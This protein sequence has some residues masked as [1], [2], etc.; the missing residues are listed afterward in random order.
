MINERPV[1]AKHKINIDSSDYYQSP[2]LL[3]TNNQLKID[4]LL[5][6]IKI[7]YGYDF[8]HYSRNL[9]EKKV[10][11]FMIDNNLDDITEV[12]KILLDDYNQF[13]R[14]LLGISIS[15][16]SFFRDPKFYQS[17]K[18]NILPI[19]KTYPFLKVWHAGCS[20][21]E[22]VYSIAMLLNEFDLLK[23]T[24]IYGTDINSKSLAAAKNG[25]YSI[26]DF[27]TCVEN[28]TSIDNP[29]SIAKYFTIDKHQVK[30][31]QFIKPNIL[32]SYHNLVSDHSF[33]EMNVIFCRNVLIY[34]SYELQNKV[35]SLLYH[36]LRTNGFL[37]LGKCESII[38]FDFKNKFEIVDNENKIY[39]KI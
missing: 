9:I 27:K 21:G 20:T 37:C 29:H 10:I 30:I 15:V 33:G 32:F 34:F 24:N 17:I 6:A 3:S 13:N 8:F 36:A 16:T 39:K 14:F 1:N 35:I 19:L 23:N 31:N 22:E 25:I 28:F 12:I 7:K 38:H 5:Y 2:T 18:T 26:H 4:T 11:Q